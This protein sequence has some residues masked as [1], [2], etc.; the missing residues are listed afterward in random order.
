MLFG[1]MVLQGIHLSP[2]LCAPVQLK[3]LAAFSAS[4]LVLK[5]AGVP[6]FG[7][8]VAQPTNALEIVATNIKEENL[9]PFKSFL[10]DSISSYCKNT[11]NYKLRL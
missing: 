3:F 4:A 1:T 7:D 2:I 6:L 10:F 11:T 9:N 8:S 5:R